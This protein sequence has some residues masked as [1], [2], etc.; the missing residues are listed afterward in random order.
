MKNPSSFRDRVIRFNKHI[1]NKLTLKWAQSSWGPFAVIYHVGRRSGKQYETPIIVQPI[2]EGFVLALTY[3][4]EVDWYR[5]IVAAGKCRIRRH[6]KD[7]AIDKIESMDTDAG[8]RA[9]PW[10]ARTILG[11][12]GAEDFVK[13]KSVSA[14]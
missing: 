14:A 4:P 2:A 10:I 11:R 8:L 13:L 7:Y 12:V 9:F 1:L 6:G 5:N 3:G